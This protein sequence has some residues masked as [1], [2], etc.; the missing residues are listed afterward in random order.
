MSNSQSNGTALITGASTGIGA[1]YADRLAKRGYDLILVARNEA[2]LQALSDRLTKETGRSVT[3]LRADLGDKA[4]LAKV[5]VD[6]KKVWQDALEKGGSDPG[7][8]IAC[9][10]YLALNGKFDHA[11]EFLKAN[12]RQGIVVRPWVYDALALALELGKGSLT[13]IERA[14]VSVVDLEPQEPMVVK[15]LVEPVRTYLVLRAKPR[16][17]RTARPS[18]DGV[19]TTLVGRDAE[20]GQLQDAFRRVYTNGHMSVVTIVAEAGLGK[21][22]LLYEFE[23]WIQGRPEHVQILRGRANPQTENQPYGL[24]REILSWQFT[25]ADSDRQ[26]KY[27]VSVGKT[28]PRTSRTAATIQAPI[29]GK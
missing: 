10:D 27:G 12:L 14:R 3:P 15:G 21:S 23:D 24:L 13:D 7:L 18:H 19:E 25:I 1:V 29:A 2:R 6:P 20:L 28:W 16:S 22:R 9:A 5:P 17:F 8:I 26:I 11:A 4:D